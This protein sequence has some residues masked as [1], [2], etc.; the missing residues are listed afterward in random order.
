[1]S[2]NVR[3]YV[4]SRGC[5]RKSASQ[6]VFM[7]SGEAIQPWDVLEIYLKGLDVKSLVVNEYSAMLDFR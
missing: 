1:M 7:L 2:G 6:K 5:R 4:L 3:E